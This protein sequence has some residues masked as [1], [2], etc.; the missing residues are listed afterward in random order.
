MYKLMKL[1]YLTATTFAALFLGSGLFTAAIAFSAEERVK[2][3]RVADK[4][5]KAADKLEA[6]QEKAADKL[7]ARQEKAADMLAGRRSLKS[8]LTSFYRYFVE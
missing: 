7:E 5:E 6:R 3:E 8:D 4:L 1:G 2:S